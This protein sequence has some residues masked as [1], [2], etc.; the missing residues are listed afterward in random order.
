[1]KQSTVYILSFLFAL[2]C[3]SCKLQ[4]NDPETPANQDQATPKS[5]SPSAT[6]L[7]W[8]PD[9]QEVYTIG[10]QGLQVVPVAGGAVTTLDARKV[11]YRSLSLSGTGTYLYCL[12]TADSFSSSHT[13]MRYRR[14]DGA[15]DTLLTGVLDYIA[16]PVSDD[17]AC[18]FSG[19]DTCVV[20]SPGSGVIRTVGRRKPGAWSPDGLSLL[21]QDTYGGYFTTLYVFRLSDGSETSLSFD[22][23]G[24]VNQLAWHSDGMKAICIESNEAGTDVYA[25]NI[26]TGLKE[27]LVFRA[28]LFFFAFDAN[29]GRIGLWSRIPT[30]SY[31]LPL[32]GQIP[33][34]WDY[35]ANVHSLTLHSNTPY[36]VGNSGNSN[37]TGGM[38]FS[39]S[40]TKMACAYRGAVTLMDV[41]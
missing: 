29:G 32:F 2:T 20:F 16:S 39:P 10:W 27:A 38:A 7:V 28:E 13:L 14:S 3:A 22:H 41:Q 25:Y 6:E 36:T 37:P 1:M 11:S 30:E 18:H 12:A 19:T 8:S 23:V 40:G 21:T 4:I 31:W 5:D 35:I 9:G 24:Y 17:V 33:T 34:K 15:A 26:T